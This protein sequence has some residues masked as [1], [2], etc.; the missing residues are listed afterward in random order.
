M[1]PPV[2]LL[3]PLKFGLLL[4]FVA[5]AFLPLFS[6]ATL[7]LNYHFWPLQARSCESDLSSRPR[8]QPTCVG[9]QGSKRLLNRSTI[10]GAGKAF[11]SCDRVKFWLSVKGRDLSHTSGAALVSQTNTLSKLS[12][13]IIGLLFS[14]NPVSSSGIWN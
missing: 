11:Q 13:W 10:R 14:P 1:H 9:F 6:V 8:G 12:F 4:S 5:T 7:L 3:L 2:F